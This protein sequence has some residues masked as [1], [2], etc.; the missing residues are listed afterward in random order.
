M[1]NLLVSIPDQK[2]FI[3]SGVSFR[4]INRGNHN[5]NN[6]GASIFLYLSIAVVWDILWLVLIGPAYQFNGSNSHIVEG[7]GAAMSRYNIYIYYAHLFIIFTKV[8]LL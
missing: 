5:F 1:N 7:M 4:T 6:Y 2:L 8:Y 3:K